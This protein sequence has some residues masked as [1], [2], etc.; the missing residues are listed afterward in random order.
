[1]S[2][3]I[4]IRHVSGAHVEA[5]SLTLSDAWSGGPPTDESLARLTSSERDA[6]DTT[7]HYESRVFANGAQTPRWLA[8]ATLLVDEHPT[9][10]QWLTNDAM[11]APLAR[12]LEGGIA[13]GTDDETPAPP[14]IDR[15]VSL[16]RISVRFDALAS[17]L[18]TLSYQV[19]HVLPASALEG[20]PVFLVNATFFEGARA[21]AIGWLVRAFPT[22]VLEDVVR[23]ACDEVPWG[24]LA[25]RSNA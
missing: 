25:T 17:Y 6:R 4:A 21:H 5:K 9:I 22:L 10:F 8:T 7:A 18:G 23:R 15:G 24:L 13:E 19:D 16:Q 12:V 11:R 2:N 1:M 3:G 14:W 20:A